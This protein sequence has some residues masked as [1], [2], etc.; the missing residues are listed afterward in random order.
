MELAFISYRVFMS[1]Q[2]FKASP[3]P[4]VKYTPT[5]LTMGQFLFHSFYSG[6]TRNSS[7]VSIYVYILSLNISLGLLLR[8]YSVTCLGV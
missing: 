3:G 1:K 5:I 8:V 6:E 4:A 7:C 2:H